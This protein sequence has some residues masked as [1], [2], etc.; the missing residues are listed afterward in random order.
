MTKQ[1]ENKDM[2]SIIGQA[3]YFNTIRENI[4][5]FEV[6]YIVGID[7]YYIYLENDYIIDRFSNVLYTNKDRKVSKDF[8]YSSQEQKLFAE[9]NQLN[10]SVNVIYKFEVLGMFYRMEFGAFIRELDPNA[11]VY[12]YINNIKHR[13]NYMATSK[14]IDIYNFGKFIYDDNDNL[15]YLT[16]NQY[17][18]KKE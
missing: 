1:K 16:P 14:S 9:V 5:F 11:A 2:E 3:I 4:T 15:I 10:Q 17:V 18:F 7:K 8:F 13:Y 6:T 12:I